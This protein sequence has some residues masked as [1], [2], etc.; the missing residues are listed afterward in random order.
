[1]EKKIKILKFRKSEKNDSIICTIRELVAG[2]LPIFHNQIVIASREL[3]I[4]TDKHYQCELIPMKTGKG[5]IA[6][7]AKEYMRNFEIKTKNN[8]QL[9]EFAVIVNFN[10]NKVYSN[11]FT[12][13]NLNNEV[14]L[15]K[16]NSYIGEFA[17]PQTEIKVK[18]LRETIENTKEAYI[19]FKKE[20]AY[21]EIIT[22]SEY[23]FSVQ[24]KF[25]DGNS[26]D[27]NFKVEGSNFDLLQSKIG[28]L[29]DSQYLNKERLKLLQETL[30]S[31]YK[32]YCKHQKSLYNLSKTAE[33]YQYDGI[34]VCKITNEIIGDKFCY[35]KCRNFIGG[36]RVKEYVQ[37]SKINELKKS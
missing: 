5:Y 15:E 3:N 18:E 17:T 20:Q 19:N 31:E 4:D 12:D 32:L 23:H 34:K 30:A 21:F 26:I 36:Y 13:Y 10:D 6:I 35:T 25:T 33:H 1:M 14:F 16:V 8:T 2:Y 24:V 37:C 7:S 29:H 28:K 27:Y 11:Y 22:D 9:A